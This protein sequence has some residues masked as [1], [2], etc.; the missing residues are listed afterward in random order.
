MADDAEHWGCCFNCGREGHCWAER[1]EPIKD[2]L[3]QAKERANRKRQSLNR[4][5][6]AGAKEARPPKTGTT[7]ADPAQAKN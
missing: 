2:S 6:G 5:G 1:T 3:K 7:K 4:D